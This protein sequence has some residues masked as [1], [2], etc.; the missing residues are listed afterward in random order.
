[1]WN[2]YILRSSSA[3]HTVADYRAWLLVDTLQDML[4]A[5]SAA[6]SGLEALS[7]QPEGAAARTGAACSHPG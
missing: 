3:C 2:E 5:A 1:M 6:A 7:I 4:C